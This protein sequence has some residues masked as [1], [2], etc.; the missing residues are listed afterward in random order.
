MPGLYKHVDDEVRLYCNLAP[1]RDGGD[2]GWFWFAVN[3]AFSCL[4]A[5]F[6][7]GLW[8]AN[9]YLMPEP[10]PDGYR[11]ALIFTF[12]LLFD[13][14]LFSYWWTAIVVSGRSGQVRRGFLLKRKLADFDAFSGIRLE[15]LAGRMWFV[16]VWRDKFKT[17]LRISPMATDRQRLARYYHEIIP[18]VAGVMNLPVFREDGVGDGASE[19]PAAAERPLEEPAVAEVAVDEVEVPVADATA[20]L[21]GGDA[22]DGQREYRCFKY[23]AKTG[24]YTNRGTV[25]QIV[26]LLLFLGVFVGSGAGVHYLGIWFLQIAWV[27]AVL[28]IFWNIRLESVSFR[29][30]PRRRSIVSYTHFGFRKNVF[31]IGDLTKI[32]ATQS[33]FMRAAVLHFKQTGTHPF[34]IVEGR[35]TG[36]VRQGIREFGQIMGVD[37][38]AMLE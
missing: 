10:E 14:Y 25:S 1:K 12:I 33:G 4:I 11:A 35:A 8:L 27:A 37:A 21:G 29:L 13:I 18:L 2:P 16:L 28:F 32:T 22:R 9:A 26:F 5:L 20:Y 19:E 34:S 38:E 17:P 36:Y 31:R 3:A 24:L 23:N 15:Q 6:T 7:L 30:D